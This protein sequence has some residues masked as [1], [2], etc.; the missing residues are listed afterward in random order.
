MKLLLLFLSLLQRNSNTAKFLRA[1][2][3]DCF[4]ISET[5]TTKNVIYTLAKNF[6][7]RVLKLFSYPFGFANVNSTKFIFAIAFFLLTKHF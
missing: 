5:E 3:N 2:A 1:H 6:N 4:C 7:F